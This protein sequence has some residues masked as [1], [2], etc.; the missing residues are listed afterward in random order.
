MNDKSNKAMFNFVRS[1]EGKIE[2][3]VTLAA[4]RKV[5]GAEELHPSFGKS[6]A[7]DRRAVLEL[8]WTAEEEIAV[9]KAFQAFLVS[10]I[11][12]EVN[13]TSDKYIAWKDLK[14]GDRISVDFEQIEKLTTE[15]RKALAGVRK[16]KA[17][18]KAAEQ[19]EILM[20]TES[21]EIDE[22]DALARLIALLKK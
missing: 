13:H 20:L 16:E 3:E 17:A 19:A 6:E 18:A 15:Q 9:A 8:T 4:N 5:D 21:G 14:A 22:K 7:K 11:W 10:K 12:Y 1:C 2:G